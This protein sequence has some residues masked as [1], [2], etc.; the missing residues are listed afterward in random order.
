MMALVVV[1]KGRL[2]LRR[3]K[4]RLRGVVVVGGGGGGGAAMNLL[5]VHGGVLGCCLLLAGLLL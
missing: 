2:G 5:K 1:F 4:S 3:L